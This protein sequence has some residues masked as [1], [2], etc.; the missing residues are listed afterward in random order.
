[1][2]IQA[3]PL[4]RHSGLIERAVQPGLVAHQ[5]VQRLRPLYAHHDPRRPIRRAVQADLHPAEIGRGEV[6]VQPMA[7]RRAAP[8]RDQCRSQLGGGR[9]LGH[10]ARRRMA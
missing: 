3:A 4:R 1:M 6:Q 10:G 2:E 5:Q 7:A 8:Q 9:A